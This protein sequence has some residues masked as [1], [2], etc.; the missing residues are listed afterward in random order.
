MVASQQ[1]RRAQWKPVSITICGL[2][3]VTAVSFAI[4]SIAHLGTVIALG[5]I[6][7][8]DP[9]PGAAIPEGVIALVLGVGSLSILAR[10]P[11][12]WG[13]ALAAALFAFFLTMYGL[14]VTAGST[15]TGDIAYHITV[16]VLS[17][18]IVGLLLLPMGRH[19]LAS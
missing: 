1:S 8:E 4:A 6:T 18:V 7:I 19:S 2:M 5:P 15:R 16:L 11:A 3:L 9:F 12:R 13:I 17:G 10:W 14:T